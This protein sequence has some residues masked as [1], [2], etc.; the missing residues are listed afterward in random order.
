[1]NRYQFEDLISD[2]L[3]NKLSIPKRKEFE[4]F[5]DS[6]SECREIVESVKN[7]MHSIRSMNP[8]IVPDG[9]MDGLNRKLEIEK[10]KP[11]SSSHAGRTY[12]GFTPVYA[13]VVSVALVCSIWL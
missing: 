10:N 1:M 9:F 3:E 7:I 8:V 5:L 12:F 4:A 6:N 2:Y 11:V 13:G